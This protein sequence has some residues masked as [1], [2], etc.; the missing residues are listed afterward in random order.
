MGTSTDGQICFGIYFPEE[1]E[2][3]WTETDIEEWWLVESGWK[4]EG[5]N[6]WTEDGNY[7]PRFSQ[8]D[9]RIDAWFDSQRDWKKSHPLPV[10]K[11]NYQSGDCPA[12]ILACPSSLIA[13]S[14]GYP[15]VFYP[16]LLNNFPPIELKA[17]IDF[18]SKYNLEYDTPPSWY[19]SSYWG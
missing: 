11:V 4:W 12:Y 17:L 5:E 6:P 10:V 1:Y 13:A 3:P 9:S 8:N 15:H 2:F 18:C 19:L 7:A 16:D 14:R